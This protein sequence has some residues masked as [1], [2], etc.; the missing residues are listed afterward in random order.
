[1]NDA[2]GFGDQPGL[3]LDVAPRIFAP[4]E[5]ELAGRQAGGTDVGFNECHF[6]GQAF[7]GTTAAAQLEHGGSGVDAGHVGHVAKTR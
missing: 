3:V 4:D 5:I 6:V 1:M 2:G 7:V